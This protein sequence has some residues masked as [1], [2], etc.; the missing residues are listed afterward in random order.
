MTNRT[1]DE[2]APFIRKANEKERRRQL[3]NAFL[4]MLFL[5]ALITGAFMGLLASKLGAF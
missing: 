4:I 2:F 5:A 1:R 3:R